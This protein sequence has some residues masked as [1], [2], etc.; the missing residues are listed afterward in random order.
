MTER[1]VASLILDAAMESREAQSL[2]QRLARPGTPT[3]LEAYGSRK[4][5]VQT[6]PS[7]GPERE[8][9]KLPGASRRSIPLFGETEKG[10]TGAERL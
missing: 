5:G 4:L 3:P 1:G 9:R 8:P 10:K 2:S 7:Q 6:G